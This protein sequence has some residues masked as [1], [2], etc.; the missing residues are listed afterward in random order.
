MRYETPASLADAYAAPAR[1]AGMIACPDRRR[2][3][4]DAPLGAGSRRLSS[5]RLSS[6]GLC[7]HAFL[8]DSA[9]TDIAGDA[10]YAPRRLPRLVIW[11]PSEVPRL[12]VLLLIRKIYGAL[13][14]HG[15]YP[16]IAAIWLILHRG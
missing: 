8:P 1:A 15:Y 16:L 10:L 12:R 2:C 6:S 13:T 11:L 4:N 5:S 9:G 14:G 7:V 3:R